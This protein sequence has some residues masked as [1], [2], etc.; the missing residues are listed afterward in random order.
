MATSMLPQIEKD[1]LDER[2]VLDNPFRFIPLYNGEPKFTVFPR[3]VAFDQPHPFVINFWP[4]VNH[5]LV[6]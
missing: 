5:G 2:W 6:R 3:D 1:F 4:E